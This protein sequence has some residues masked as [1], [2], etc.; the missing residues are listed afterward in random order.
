[1]TTDK[2]DEN[3]TAFAVEFLKSPNDAFKAALNVFPSDTGRA[4]R[5]AHEWPKDAFVLAEQERLSSEHG[6]GAFLPT[7]SD[8]SR[9][10][11]ERLTPTEGVNRVSH[12]DFVKLARLY[13]EVRSFIVKPETNV[14]VA[15]TTNKVMVVKDL[16]S[17]EEWEMKA[18]KQQRELVNVSTSRH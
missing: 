16:G 5:A 14:N 18:A 6:E 11:W 7:K 2:E 1:M 12:D 3:K 8:L 15:V 10:I 17:N 9:A 4:L 13:A